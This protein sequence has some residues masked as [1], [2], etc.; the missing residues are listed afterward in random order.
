MSE[1]AAFKDAASVLLRRERGLAM[2]RTA[3]LLVPLA[4]VVFWPTLSI[5]GD[6]S[7]AAAN[8]PAAAGAGT[9]EAT[10]DILAT[11]NGTPI[12]EIDVRYKLKNDSRTA[13]VTPRYR[14]NAIEAII[15]EEIFSQRAV[16][17]GLDADP[18]YQEKL[19][20]M[21]AQLNAFK[22]KELT[23][24]FFRRE[25]EGKA[26]VSETEAN[27]YFVQNAARIRTELHVWQILQKG[28]E[29]PIEQALRDIKNG[30]PFEKVA[31]RRFPKLPDTSQRPWDLGYL[32]WQQVPAPWQNVIYDLKK[33]QVSGIIRGPGKR[34]WIIK[35]IDKRENRDVTFESLRPAIVEVLKSERMEQ[36]REKVERDL[37]NNSRIVYSKGLGPSG[38]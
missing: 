37:R 29:G 28:E 21:E 18:A 38:E 36:L 14:Q 8:Q 16:E 11:V 7:A 9:S 35:L 33:G 23:G 3:L 25:I 17:L 4:A 2:P 32:R 34:F 15:R 22:R 26:I 6:E 5:G 20:Q 1:E 10:K 24:V 27:E 30:T 31:E 19:R 13:E 12:S